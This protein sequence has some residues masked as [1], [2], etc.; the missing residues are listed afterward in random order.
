MQLGP[1]IVFI[2]LK[3]PMYELVF[4]HYVRPQGPASQMVLHDCYISGITPY[5]LSALSIRLEGQQ[6]TNDM[7]I[8][9]AKRFARKAF[10][11]SK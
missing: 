7:Y 4:H 3:S 1:S 9:E 8:W 6:V 2:I 5:W 10:L 11:Q